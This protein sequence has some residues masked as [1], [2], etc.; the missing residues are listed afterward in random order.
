MKVTKR[1]GRVVE[2]DG[3]KIV[4]AVSKAMKETTGIVNSDLCYLIEE[5]VK[6]TLI[7]GNYPLTVEGIQ[8][9]VENSLMSIGNCNEVAKNYI[10]YRAKRNEERKKGWE[11]TELQ[12]DIYLNKYKYENESFDEFINRVSGGNS[13][14]AKIIRNQDFSFG[15]RI[16]AGRGLNRNVTMSNCYVLPQPDDNIESIFDVAKMMARTYSYGGKLIASL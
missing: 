10:L 4:Q 2:Y 14:V 7:A 12:K 9:S 3:I 1:D 6:K 5:E 16:L 13:E 11:M 15:G 8:D